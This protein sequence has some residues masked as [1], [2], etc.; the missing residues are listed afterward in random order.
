MTQAQVVKLL[1]PVLLGFGALIPVLVTAVPVAGRAGTKALLS[2]ILVIVIWVGYWVASFFSDFW[3]YSNAVTLVALTGAAVLLLVVF[4]RLQS[5]PPSSP[6]LLYGYLAGL[7]LVSIAAAN[8]VGAAGRDVVE[9][10]CNETIAEVR[11]IGGGEHDTYDLSLRTNGKIA[12]ASL[13][14]EEFELTE[15][16]ELVTTKQHVQAV[17]PSAAQRLRDPG[18]GRKFRFSVA[19]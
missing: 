16:F 15:R 18:L 8:Y 1:P 17:S 2:V 11:R 19:F 12:R 5:V 14:Q 9:F 4:I 3:S 13:T 7:L 6:N 10:T